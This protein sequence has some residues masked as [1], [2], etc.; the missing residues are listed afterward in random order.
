[1]RPISQSN[2]DV[3]TAVNEAYDLVTP[4]LRGTAFP[5]F[6]VRV[7][8]DA[9]P[10]FISVEKQRGFIFARDAHNRWGS[11]DDTTM[12][13]KDKAAFFDRVIRAG[14]PSTPN[15]PG[16]SGVMSSPLSH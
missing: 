6:I 1:M 13:D 10:G 16:G 9:S 4:R 3:S 11:L 8:I 5:I 7:L 15:A 14:L 2:H 12:S